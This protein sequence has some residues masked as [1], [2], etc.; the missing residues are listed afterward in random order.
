MNIKKIAEILNYEYVGNFNGDISGITYF[1]MAGENDIAIVRR[2]FEILSTNAKAVLTEPRIL[3][4]E[5]TLLYTHEPIYVSAIKIAKLLENSLK[6]SDYIIGKNCIIEPDVFIGKNVVIGNGVIL[7]SGAKIGASAFYHYEDFEGL[8]TFQGIGKVIISDNVEIG[9]NSVIQRGTFGDTVI[10]H[11]TKIG[12]LVDVGHDVK[13]GCN[14][15]IVSQVGI[16][17]NVFIGNGVKIFG[18]SGISNFV[19]IGNGAKIMAKSL[20]TKNV[21]SGA[22][23]SG[24]FARE[25]LKALRQNAKLEKLLEVQ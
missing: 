7:H 1:D 9:Y 17:G 20:V 23:V 16:A 4:T 2:D 18:Q 8:K 25:H 13:I 5:K 11:D 10:G 24:N 14:C 22:V 3:I 15:K 21:K 12:N 19:R 6:H